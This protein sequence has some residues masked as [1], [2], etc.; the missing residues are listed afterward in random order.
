MCVAPARPAQGS[1][2]RYELWY[3]FW[4]LDVLTTEKVTKGLTWGVRFVI[5]EGFAFV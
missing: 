4:W 2:L 3:L 1:R 5:I